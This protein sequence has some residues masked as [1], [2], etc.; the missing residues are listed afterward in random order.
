MVVYFKSRI[1]SRYI[2]SEHIRINSK[3]LSQVY[4]IIKE[5]SM[6]IVVHICNSYALEEFVYTAALTAEQEEIRD[7]RL[8]SGR[9]RLDSDPVI[10]L[11]TSKQG[12]TLIEDRSNVYFLITNRSKAYK[13][14][15]S[16][17][18]ELRL[19]TEDKKELKMFVYF[20]SDE[21]CFY[22]T[23]RGRV[24]SLGSSLNQTI[25]YVEAP[26]IARKHLLLKRAA[27]G[28]R[29]NVKGKEGCYLN[30]RYVGFMESAA[31]GCGDVIIVGGLRLLWLDEHIGVERLHA[32]QTPDG[33]RRLCIV[34]L[35]RIEVPADM[36]VNNIKS[37][38]EG[39]S[40]APRN[41]IIPDSSEI[42]LD[43]PPPKHEII[44][45]PAY[46]TVGPSLTMAV[47]MCLGCGMYIYSS[48]N[49]GVGNAAI[50][51]YTGIITAITSALLGAAWAIVNIRHSRK[52]M[53]KE[54]AL[55][56][57][58]Y[59]E[60][61]DNCNRRLYE[62]YL[63]NQNALRRNY[64]SLNELFSNGRLMGVWNRNDQDE[65]LYRYRL[66]TGNCPFDVKLRIPK[67]KFNM[68]EDE[69]TGLPKKLASKFRELK[70]VPVCIDLANEKRIGLI[71]HEHELKQLFV[72]L[73]LQAASAAE[74]S[75]VKIIVLLS[76][77][78]FEAGAVGYLRW[79][80]NVQ[81]DDEH[82]ICIGSERVEE[83]LCSLEGLL[84]VNGFTGRWIIFT[85]E[86]CRL[87]PSITDSENV[88]LI[89]MA[90]D[91]GSLPGMCTAVIQNDRSFRGIL[92]KGGVRNEIC[93]DHISEEKAR[94]YARSLAGIN[95]RKN[96]FH[97]PIPDKVTLPELYDTGFIT[98][99]QINDN[100]E[101]NNA[102]N[103]LRMPI[104][105]AADRRVV[106]LDLHEKAHG[107]H[108][109][110]AGMTGS[111]KSEMLQTLV[112]SLAI[113]YPPDEVG[114][115]LIDYKGGGMANLF[116][117][118]PHVM[119]SISNLSGNVINRA[120][121]SIRSENERRQ[122]L[123]LNAGVNSIKD[124]GKMYLRGQVTEPLPHIMIIIDEFAEL[125]REEPDFMKELISVAQVGRSLGVHLILATQKPAGTVDDNI[126]SN[127]RF[128]ICLRV[129]DKQDSNDMLHRPDAAFISNP[130]RAF[131]QVGNDELFEE[132]QAGYT[133]EPY[134]ESDEDLPA[135]FFLDEHGHR[136]KININGH[137]RKDEEHS[138][139]F[140]VIMGLIE[141]NAR[142]RKPSDASR[143]WL[144]PLPE[145]IVLSNDFK[146]SGLKGIHIGKYDIIAGRFDDPERQR[147]AD[148]HLD[149]IRDG[150]LVICGSSMSGKST[151]LQTFVFSHI[152]KHSPESLN[153]YI[154]DFSNGTLSAFGS[155]KMTGA[156]ITEENKERLKYLFYMLNEIMGLRRKRFEGESFQQRIDESMTDEPA[157]MLVI[158]GYGNFREKTECCY[159]RDIQELLKLGETY[160]IYVI[161]SGCSI[162]NN[163]IPSRVFE[164]CRTGICLRLNDKYQYSECLR[165][166]R[167]TL[168]PDAGIHGRG[169]AKIEGKIL[170]FQTALCH[171]GN[172]RERSRYIRDCIE[173][174]N[175]GCKSTAVMMPYIPDEP[176]LTD[177]SCSAAMFSYKK[178][179]I[180]IGYD[181]ES[182]KPFTVKTNVTRHIIFAGRIGSGKTNACNVFRYFAAEKGHTIFEAGN[183]E[184]LC[185]V[186]SEHPEWIIICD[187]MS[188]MIERF[189]ERDFSRQIEDELLKNIMNR[190]GVR[191]VGTFAT[192]DHSG[193]VGRK[194]Y[195]VIRTEC[196][197]IYLG[198]G[199]DRQSIFDCSY[200]PYS[201]QCASKSPGTGTVLKS[202]A[203]SRYGDIVI[204]FSVDNEEV[205]YDQNRDICNTNG[206]AV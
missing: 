79:L 78:L 157:I 110:I 116:K 158:D 48:V 182:G 28:G 12:I 113:R 204:P 119:G 59:K 4:Y 139:H 115:F 97:T 96:A 200:I 144:P 152:V 191:F 179:E 53:L 88:T 27:D 91:Y 80:P 120:M 82:Y 160:G 15:I 163:D 121:I 21:M 65:D 140:S 146:S 103:S 33:S 198:G 81:G 7:I 22:Q 166:P 118:L 47:P 177:L 17:D 74:P 206:A 102:Q 36:P 62:K 196:M 101:R 26:G 69:L 23:E 76:G 98:L 16:E 24:I 20:D 178:G 193:I 83:M 164:N 39:F 190:K 183:I 128:R 109:L 67:D 112:L 42:E 123:F 197:G 201:V 114:F 106:F 147:Q 171:D 58:A 130:G 63:Y 2:D 19:I 43:A 64:P 8:P 18:T 68:V 168:F 54:E 167:L 35:S 25:S 175:K 141:K 165:Q 9:F 95:M 93:F 86:V 92:L 14:T 52:R 85:D 156:Y 136:H 111:G 189:Y 137:D 50:Y 195:E 199:L 172:D 202:K 90:R 73:I 155:S 132:F 145:H 142:K 187:G 138:T 11:S 41:L 203:N 37:I 151:F 31:V 133:M 104:G 89:V 32:E 185:A 125:K 77:D 72:N 60:Y 192:E 55:R 127:S 70:D 169:L 30:N 148:M 129:Q 134:I 1:E 75:F 61:I 87:S 188:R 194:L 105:M 56:V 131:L 174:L 45:Q 154:L 51:M 149:L 126:F 159:D 124:Y 38:D 117:D 205:D 153:I 184:E 10:V 100:W 161:L 46:I 66:G 108:G 143:L 3:R 99:E 150:H 107:P 84:N 6:R 181:A 40:P 71:G 176:I 13:N 5:V 170:E 186:A 29:L 135:V 34:R 94:L 49:S 122:R 173:G 180:P 44:K 57:R 162:G